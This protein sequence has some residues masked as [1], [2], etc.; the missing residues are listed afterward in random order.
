MP[1]NKNRNL[2]IAFIIAVFMIIA[3]LDSL[4]V[5][6]S[7]PYRMVPHGNH[8]HYVPNNYDSNVPIDSFP[9]VPPGPGQRI[10]REGKIV[11]KK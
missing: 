10:T 11:M 5:F 9:T 3:L 7:K 4:D 1:S 8:T 6:N 2:I